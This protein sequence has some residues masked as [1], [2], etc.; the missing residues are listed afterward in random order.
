MI[1]LKKNSI[2][3]VDGVIVC[4]CLLMDDLIDLIYYLQFLLNYAP[5]RKWTVL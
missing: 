2:A 5:R 4:V 3:F 1:Y